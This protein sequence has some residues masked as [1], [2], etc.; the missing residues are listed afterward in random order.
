[1]APPGWVLPTLP[2]PPNIFAA[3]PAI[4]GRFFS[5]KG[6]RFFFQLGGQRVVPAVKEADHGN[7]GN[8]LDDLILGIILL[9]IGCVVVDW[10]VAYGGYGHSETQ[11]ESFYFRKQVAGL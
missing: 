3:A 7:Y 10:Q 9:P 5:A 11:C 6:Y 2:L 4:F 8:D 1:M